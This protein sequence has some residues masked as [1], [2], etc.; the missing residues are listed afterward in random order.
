MHS[1]RRVAFIVVLAF[2]VLLP[3]LVFA[4]GKK[5]EGVPAPQQEST[6]PREATPIV[7]NVDLVAQVNGRGIEREQYDF[8]LETNVSQYEAQGQQLTPEQQNELGRRLL[9]GLITREVLLQEAERTNI[10]VTDT[11]FQTALEQFK[12][13]FP[14]DSQYQ[15]ALE[16]QGFT[17]EQFEEELTVQLII[18]KLVTRDVLSRIEVSDEDARSFYES[19]PEMFVQGEQVAARHILIST[20]DLQTDAEREEA[21]LRADAVHERLLAGEDFA[22]LAREVSEGPSGP[23]GGDLGTFGRGQMVQ[24]FE[25]AAFG[26]DVDQI[27]EVVETQFGYHII[28]VTEKINAWTVEFDE[29]KDRI[30]GYLGEQQQGTAVQAYVA[31]L[32]DAS[33][34]ETFIELD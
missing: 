10:E 3:G 11:E 27:S 17:V 16:T 9:E 22:E 24:P 18:E 29:V 33:E 6:T 8:L 32:K 1:T 21:K 12:S 25:E 4:G 31:D 15:I 20:Q 13:Q 34:I 28:Q 19:N 26:L 2:L 30:I 23:N 14:N 7:T 5:E